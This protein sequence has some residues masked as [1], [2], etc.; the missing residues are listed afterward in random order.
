MFEK[1]VGIVTVADRGT[2]LSTLPD[3]H[4]T[5]GVGDQAGT[6][7]AGSQPALIDRQ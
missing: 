6:A 3:N 4:A 2:Q 1:F 5:V 7:V